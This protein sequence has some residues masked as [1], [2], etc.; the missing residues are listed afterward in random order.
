MLIMFRPKDLRIT[1]SLAWRKDLNFSQL[2][3]LIRQFYQS[4]KHI[5]F[6]YLNEVLQAKIWK[7]IDWLINVKIRLRAYQ[8]RNTG[9]L[10]MILNHPPLVY[11]NIYNFY[12]YFFLFSLC[13]NWNLIP[14]WSLFHHW[15]SERGILF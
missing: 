5:F 8:K 4:N 15:S 11:K 7:M 6:C 1:Q 9:A 14:K 12:I 13:F 3:I 10:F 2:H